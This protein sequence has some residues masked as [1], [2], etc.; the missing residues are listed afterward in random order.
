MQMLEQ[1]QV[2]R[3]RL[4]SGVGWDEKDERYVAELYLGLDATGHRVRKRFKGPRKDKSDDAMRGL[5]DAVEQYRQSRP[6]PK[7]GR[8]IHGR[9]T[10]SDYLQLWHEG[11]TDIAEAT[12]KRYG[13]AIER[14]LIPKLGAL[15]LHNLETEHVKRLFAQLTTLSKESKRNIR[16]A[17]HSAIEDAVPKY[18]PYNPVSKFQ[19]QGEDVVR[20]QVIW[21]PQECQRFVVAI[22]R[23]PFYAMILLMLAGGLGPAE[24]FGLRW[25]NVD[26]KRG[27]AY[28]L[29]NLTEVA[30]RLIAKSVK[31]P[32]RQRSVQIPSDALAILRTRFRDEQPDLDAYVFLSPEGTAMRRTNFIRRFWNPLL[33]AANVRRITPYGLRHE[34][35]SLGEYF[36]LSLLETSRAMGHS[37]IKTTANRYG[38]LFED[39]SS[40]FTKKLDTFIRDAKLK[41]Q[42]EAKT[43]SAS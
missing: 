26:L 42:K 1:P 10:L 31:R 9:L 36:G 34:R 6:A 20:K 33:K 18:I 19:I 37:N 38:H 11:K 32:S 27:K 41:A 17:L 16:S 2:R 24:V 13:W 14:Y 25:H 43:I 29:E 15:R 23:S 30:G 7:R 5:R 40:N 8:V 3:R 12:Y 22:V 28:I 21:N 4:P 39:A 35:A